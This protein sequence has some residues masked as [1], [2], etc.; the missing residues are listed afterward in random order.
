M[1][2][3]HRNRMPNCVDLDHSC[4]ANIIL[5]RDRW[6][7][8][9]V[10]RSEHRNVFRRVKGCTTL[11][12]ILS[13]GVHTTLGAI[14]RFT[15]DGH[16][17]VAAIQNLSNNMRK[18]PCTSSYRQCQALPIAKKPQMVTFVHPPVRRQVMPD[19]KTLGPRTLDSPGRG[20]ALHL[21][22][23]HRVATSSNRPT[24]VL[25]EDPSDSKPGSVTANHHDR[26]IQW[27][28]LTPFGLFV[29]ECF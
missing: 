17:E 21:I 16:F 8:L 1:T 15:L 10:D 9:V 28:Y 6:R 22:W 27:Q 20:W 7:L 2:C 14:H 29:L 4:I 3:N 19:K 23:L 26:I 12:A 25:V 11:M 5:P 24:Y 13:T 18:L